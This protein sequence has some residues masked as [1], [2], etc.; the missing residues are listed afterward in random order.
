[1]DYGNEH[2]WIGPKDETRHLTYH[3]QSETTQRRWFFSQDLI[4]LDPD[5]SEFSVRIH[6]PRCR[7]LSF[8]ERTLA[9]LPKSQLRTI[10]NLIG[11]Y[12]DDQDSKDNG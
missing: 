10:H 3:A 11:D 1:M 8:I 4:E 2:D 6:D 12:L 9:I 7:S 5:Y